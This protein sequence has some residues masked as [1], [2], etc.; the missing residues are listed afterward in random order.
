[1]TVALRLVST[2]TGEVLLTVAT[3]KTVFSVTISGNALTFSSD[4][5]KYAEAELGVAGNEP[6][7]LALRA[8]IDQSVIELVI[9]GEHKG[10]WKFKPKPVKQS[11][12]NTPRTQ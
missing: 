7:N 4:G 10:L 5:T 3:T 1:M 6:V 12:N 11:A 2:N 9:Q 8:A